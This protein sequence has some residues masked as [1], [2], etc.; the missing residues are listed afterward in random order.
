M[1]PDQVREGF[2]E[3]VRLLCTLKDG[4]DTNRK[5]AVGGHSV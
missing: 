3:A 5:R 2:V 1:G 4:N